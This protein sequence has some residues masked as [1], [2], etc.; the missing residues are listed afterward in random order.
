[1]DECIQEGKCKENCS[2]IV[3]ED[4][5]N[6]RN[7][8]KMKLQ[9]GIRTSPTEK[10]VNQ[11][12][13][14]CPQCDFVSQNKTILEQHVKQA[15]S[16]QPTCPFCYIGYSNHIALRKHIDSMHKEKTLQIYRSGEQ[17]NNGALQ[18]F[19]SSNGQFSSPVQSSSTLAR[20]RGPCA[21]FLQPRGCKKGSDCDF[22]HEETRIS[23]VR[24]L[25]RNGPECSWKPGCKFIHLEDGEVMPPRGQKVQDFVM[26]DLSQPPPIINIRSSTE[27]PILRKESVF[28]V[29]PQFQRKQGPLNNT[30]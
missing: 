2:H 21:F 10:S 7:L 3:E 22:S 6:L 20:K 4:L 19:S 28:R 15:H 24:K 26:P 27:F 1:M 5:R 8:R 23:K 16:H 17:D 29:N 9:G 14:R 12:V 25:C 11:V 18:S 13:H 30:L